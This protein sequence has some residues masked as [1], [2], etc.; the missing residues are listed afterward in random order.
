MVSAK[1]ASG[2]GPI[3]LRRSSSVNYQSARSKIARKPAPCTWPNRLA[4]AD[5]GVPRLTVKSP[6]SVATVTRTGHATGIRRSTGCSKR[7][8]CKSPH[9][10]P[11]DR[12]PSGAQSAI[13]VGEGDRYRA[14][15]SSATAVRVSSHQPCGFRS[16]VARRADGCR[17]SSVPTG[18]IRRRRACPS[19]CSQAVKIK[20]SGCPRAIC[21]VPGLQSAAAA[22]AG[23]GSACG[24]R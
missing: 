3:D 11:T 12:H 16:C 9:A 1:K 14:V 6:P 19:A 2:R 15:Q 20:G 10:R 18:R 7:A 5:R 8:M 13:G 17:G 21:T 23:L 4:P 22:R 24:P